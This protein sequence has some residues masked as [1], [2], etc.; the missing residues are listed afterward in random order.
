M[1]NA[2]NELQRVQKGMM[3]KEQERVVPK[4]IGTGRPPAGQGGVRV[5]QPSSTGS[6]GLVVDS[7]KIAVAA[8]GEDGH[9]FPKDATGAAS[10]SSFFEAKRRVKK[11]SKDVCATTSFWTGVPGALFS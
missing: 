8:I 1:T 4:E 2:I 3:H 10:P 5:T 9:S 11:T 6:G 7:S